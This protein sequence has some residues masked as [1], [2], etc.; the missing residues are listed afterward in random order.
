MQFPAHV[1][2]PGRTPLRSPLSDDERTGL[3]ASIKAEGCRE[4]IIVWDGTIVDGHNRYEICTRLGIE[5]QVCEKFFPNTD[6]VI[7]WIIKNQFGRRNI[8]LYDRGRLAL[9]LEAVY[10]ARAKENL[11]AVGGDHKSPF[12][13]SGNPIHST[14]NTERELAKIAGTSH[15]TIH[16]VKTIEAKA[17]P[18]QKADLSAGKAGNF[19]FWG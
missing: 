14:V 5:F 10:Q 7:E 3:E 1:E 17:T 15:D 4:A 9:R 16:K 8:Q 18:E 2:A 12:Q 13:K 6:A 11:S 19:C